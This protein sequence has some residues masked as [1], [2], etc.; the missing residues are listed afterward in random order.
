MSVVSGASGTAVPD[1]FALVA[2]ACSS[3]ARMVLVLREKVSR[4]LAKL[5]LSGKPQLRSAKCRWGLPRSAQARRQ[6]GHHRRQPAPVYMAPPR[7]R[8]GRSGTDVGRGRCRNDLRLAKTRASVCRSSRTRNRWTS[9]S[10]CRETLPQIA[11]IIYEDP[12]GLRNYDAPFDRLEGYASWGGSRPG[13]GKRGNASIRKSTGWGTVDVSVMLYTSGTTGKP[14]KG[15]C[16]SHPPSSPRP[17]AAPI[18]QAE[19]RRQRVAV[20]AHGLGGRPSVQ[21]CP[22]AGGRIYCQLPG[23]RRHGDDRPARNRADLLLRAARVF[24]TVLTR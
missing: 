12:A 23:I 24:E 9:R 11:H 4:Y 21:L 18:R 10:E 13:R 19:R 6:P 7:S 5:D 14:A 2:A 15:V 20:F 22:G 1:T 16:Q 8:L 17:R 3:I